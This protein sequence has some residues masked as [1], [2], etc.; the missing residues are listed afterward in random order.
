VTTWTNPP[1]RAWVPDDADPCAEGRNCALD[2][3]CPVY[4]F[5]E[6]HDDC[7]PGDDCECQID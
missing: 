5:C 7:E 2:P 4:E 6:A 3:D 1:E